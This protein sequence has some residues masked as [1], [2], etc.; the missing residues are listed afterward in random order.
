MEERTSLRAID[1]DTI[2]V[3]A[4]GAITL[5]ALA[6]LVIARPSTAGVI[7]LA[8]AL[9]GSILGTLLIAGPA[10]LAD[11]DEVTEP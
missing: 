8:T 1:W 4:A 10:D 11:P 6:V 5:T 9:I 7:L 2:G 3:I